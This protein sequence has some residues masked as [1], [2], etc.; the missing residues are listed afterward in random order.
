MSDDFFSSSRS[1]D[2]VSRPAPAVEEDDLDPFQAA[3][4]RRFQNA[5]PSTLLTSRIPPAASAVSMPQTPG[6]FNLRPPLPKSR[7]TARGPV[8]T[9]AL[10]PTASTS[11]TAAPFQA[12]GGPISQSLISSA[13]V[14]PASLRGAL[15][16]TTVTTSTS[17]PTSKHTTNTPGLSNFFSYR[18]QDLHNVLDDPSAPSTSSSPP[19]TI[20]VDIRNHHQYVTSRVK[21][22]INLSVPSTLLK[23]PA[24]VLSRLAEM[25]PLAA[26]R[27][28]FNAWRSASQIIVFDADTVTLT[29]GNNVDGLLKK[30]QAEGFMGKLGFIEGGFNRMIKTAEGKSYVETRPLTPPLASDSE[31][32]SS[33]G[34]LL[35]RQLPSS[36]FQQCKPVVLISTKSQSR[37]RHRLCCACVFA[38]H[39]LT[40]FLLDF[41]SGLTPSFNPL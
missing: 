6:G 22:S 27:T 24:Y 11:T 21:S 38:D 1:S 28:R 3:L 19:I 29:P 7:S 14:F 18:P 23:R 12:P 26:D 25:I 8:P 31:D 13:T 39:V 17:S 34:A 10:P 15:A 30:F 5:T 2:K 40:N 9:L 32:Q 36:A 20:V 35:S 37:R 16:S 41:T 33:G 4:G